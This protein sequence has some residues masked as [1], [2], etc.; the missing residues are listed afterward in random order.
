[1]LLRISVN[2]VPYETVMTVRTR[3]LAREGGDA[4][5]EMSEE[6]HRGFVYVRLDDGLGG[7]FKATLDQLDGADVTI[8]HS[9]PAAVVWTQDPTPPTRVQIKIAPSRL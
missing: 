9:T 5:I 7:V 1:M 8:I 4:T 3:L 2:D 6:V